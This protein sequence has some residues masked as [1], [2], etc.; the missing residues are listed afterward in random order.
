[1]NNPFV[2]EVRALLV[3]LGVERA[4]LVD[5]LYNHRSFGDALAVFQIHR[6][7]LRFVRDR[8]IESAEVA[9]CNE[10]STFFGFYQLAVWRGWMSLSDYRKCLVWHDYNK[11]PP[12]GLDL[13]TQ[14][15]WIVEDLPALREALGGATFETTRACLID[16]GQQLSAAHPNVEPDP[17]L[18]AED[19]LGPSRYNGDR[20][21]EEKNWNTAR[22]CYERSKGILKPYQLR[23]LEF[24]R[25]RLP[26]P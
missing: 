10:P 25:R 4:S 18:T 20:A 12:A 14:T 13:R 5:E 26:S 7:L 17:N 19:R 16:V 8:M 2:D 9:S 21:W 6:L 1:M 22:D 23:R 15:T 3:G 11:P 24:L